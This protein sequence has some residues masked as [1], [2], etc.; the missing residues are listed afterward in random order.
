[1][2]PKCTLN[3]GEFLKTRMNP[4]NLLRLARASAFAVAAA[5]AITIH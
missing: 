5:E 4:Q 1:M 3:S 2:H